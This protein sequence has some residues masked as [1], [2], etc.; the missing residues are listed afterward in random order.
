MRHMLRLAA[1]AL[2]AAL[3]MAVHAQGRVP[4]QAR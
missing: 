4:E 1:A 2:L 3:P